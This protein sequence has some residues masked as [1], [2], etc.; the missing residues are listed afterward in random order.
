MKS[1]RL[2]TLLLILCLFCECTQSKSIIVEKVEA[3]GANTRVFTN[4]SLFSSVYYYKEGDC[5]IQRQSDPYEVSNFVEASSRYAA[6]HNASSLTPEDIIPTHYAITVFPKSEDEV[7]QVL[8]IDG[9]KVS[10]VPFGFEQIDGM[11][12]ND[13][14]DKRNTELIYSNRVNTHM[15]FPVMF[16]VVPRGSS[17]PESIDQ[18]LEYEAYIPDYSTAADNGTIKDLLEIESIAISMTDPER[19]PVSGTRGSSYRILGAN[20]WNSDN[21]LGSLP[22]PN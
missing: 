13:K 18:Q 17:V 12:V 5:W 8:S 19:G 1:Y 21:L 22:V 20:I 15:G 7:N 6:E 11:I 14:L 9:I 10:S 3:E 4:E 16:V 2:T